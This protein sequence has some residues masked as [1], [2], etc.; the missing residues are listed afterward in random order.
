[1]RRAYRRNDSVASTD[2]PGR[3]DEVSAADLVAKRL[4]VRLKA[5]S[6]SGTSL[7]EIS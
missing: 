2:R 6:R 5:L 4:S 3:R 1:M 7:G